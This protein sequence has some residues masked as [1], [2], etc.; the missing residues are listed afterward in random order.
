MNYYQ[1][2]SSH[3]SRDGLTLDQ[4]LLTKRIMSCYVI[5]PKIALPIRQPSILEEEIAYS[6]SIPHPP[7]DPK[8]HINPSNP[9]DER[10]ETSHCRE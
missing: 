3:F 7:P 1:L 10:I 4:D 6:N 9:I 5:I 2:Y 8:S